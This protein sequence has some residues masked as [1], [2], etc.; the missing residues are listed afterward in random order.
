MMGIV[1]FPQT[2]SLCWLR[3]GGQVEVEVEE[4]APKEKV[5]KKQ[6]SNQDASSSTS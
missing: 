6:P 2:T 5:D 1:G 4:V 3:V